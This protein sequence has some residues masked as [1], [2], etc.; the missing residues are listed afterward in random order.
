MR[1]RAAFTLL[2]LL[3][4]LTIV[5]VLLGLLIPAVQKVRAA[6]GRLS[7]TNNLK[8][9]GLAS[10]HYASAHGDFPPGVFP[11]SDLLFGLNIH[12]ALL[13]YLEQNA[14]YQQAESDCATMPITHLAPPHVGLRTLVKTYQCPVDSRQSF[15]HRIP[16]GSVVAV[17]GYLGVSGVGEEER[18]SGMIYTFS[19]TRIRDVSDGTSN[20]LYFG[21][22]PPTPDYRCSWWYMSFAHVASEPFLPINAVRGMPEGTSLGADYLACHPGPYAFTPGDTTSVCHAYHFWSMHPGGAN[23]AFADSSVRFITYAANDIMPA[24]A[25]RAGGEVVQLPD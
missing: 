14:L 15:L 8:Q 6:A 17:T 19:R 3:I 10:H 18:P 9:I 11:P 16:Q 25:T 13:P 5:S 24:L 2:E 20:T 23:F 22:R 4:V 12:V 21:E 7:C 1:K